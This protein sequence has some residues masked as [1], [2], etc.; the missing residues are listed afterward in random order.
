[1]NC[2]LKIIENAWCALL[3]VL[4]LLAGLAVILVVL[5]LSLVGAGLRWLF[6]KWAAKF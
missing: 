4:C 5:P 3:C 6:P 1:M 2:G